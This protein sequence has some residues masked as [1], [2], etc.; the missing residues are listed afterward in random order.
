MASTSTETSFSEC[1]TDRGAEQRTAAPLMA[2]LSSHQE[3]GTANELL[4]ASWFLVLLRT[5]QDTQVL[6]EWSY[7][8]S[9]Q[10]SPA[11]AFFKEQ[12]LP[13]RQ[14]S[15]RQLIGTISSHIQTSKALAGD[16]ILLSTGSLLQDSETVCT[17]RRQTYT[18]SSYDK[19]GQFGASRNQHK[20]SSPVYSSDL[21]QR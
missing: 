13:S 15:V 5:S 10:S 11:T 3:L 9:Q 12:H 8:T 2:A 6:F 4:L 19:A 21:A 17:F 1:W 16:S 14:C 20:R 18:A 7:G